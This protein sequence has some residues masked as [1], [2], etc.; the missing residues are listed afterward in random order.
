MHSFIEEAYF[1][2]DYEKYSFHIHIIHTCKRMT[3]ARYITTSTTT[4]MT[5]KRLTGKKL[6]F[7]TFKHTIEN[8]M[9][10]LLA[11]FRNIFPLHEG[12]TFWHSSLIKLSIVSHIRVTCR[13]YIEQSHLLV[14]LKPFSTEHST[15]SDIA[16]KTLHRFVLEADSV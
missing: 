9:L 11:P 12:V 5:H 1:S 6:H 10:S 14:D 2:L 4:S 8:Y 13:N 16:F 3:H 15:Q 7:A